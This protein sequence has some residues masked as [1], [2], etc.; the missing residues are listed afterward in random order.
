MGFVSLII[1]LVFGSTI[2][3]TKY[4][5][6]NVPP[7][8]AADTAVIC[9]IA[10][11]LIPWPKAVVANSTGPTLFKLK[12]IPD[13]SPFRSIPVFLPKPKSLIY[14]NNLYLPSLFPRDTKP[15]LQEF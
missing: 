11:T 14:L 12:S 4:G 3:L 7:L 9:C 5:L 10:L 15:G 8:T 1:S 6:Y 2:L 13:D